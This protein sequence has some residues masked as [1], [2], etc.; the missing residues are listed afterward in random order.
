MKLNDTLIDVLQGFSVGIV[1]LMTFFSH[2]I[3][4]NVLG[5]AISLAVIYRVTKSH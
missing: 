5:I 1:C 4:V 3:W 2:S